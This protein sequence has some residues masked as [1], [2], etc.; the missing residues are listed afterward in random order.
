MRGFTQFTDVSQDQVAELVAKNRLTGTAAEAAF[1]EQAR[2]TL[3]T[4]NRYL[5]VVADTVIARDGLLDKF[6]GDCVMAFWGAPNPD[7]HHALACVRAALEAQRA[8]YELNRQRAKENQQRE[9]ENQARVSAGL[10]PKPLLPILFLGTGINTGMATVGMMGS[11]VKTV[12]RQANYTVFGREVNLASRL[13]G[14]S[15]RGR[16]YISETTYQHL[17]RD[18]PAL[19]ATSIALAPVAVKGFRNAVKV[20]EVPWRPPG[21][22][23]LEDEFAVAPTPDTTTFAHSD[24]RA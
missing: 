11:E 18:D 15:G 22:P 12:V 8:I 24:A 16:I 1:D 23:P 6:I 13:E 2:E 4:V 20:Y 14:A 9:I 3:A 19:A 17:L 7:P 5:G 21:S 10:L